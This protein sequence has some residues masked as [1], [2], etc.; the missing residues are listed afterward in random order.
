MEE[1]KQLQKEDLA[2][3]RQTVAQMPPQMLELPYRRSEMKE[4][5]QR[6]LEFAFEDMYN[7]DRSKGL[8]PVLLNVFV[9]N[10]IC[11]D[12]QCLFLN[13]LLYKKD[14]HALNLEIFFFKLFI[15]LLYVSTL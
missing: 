1:L 5:R 11:I 14:P 3:R 4:D 7:A 12:K 6:E 13:E 2:R 15:Y 8:S 9:G 10:N